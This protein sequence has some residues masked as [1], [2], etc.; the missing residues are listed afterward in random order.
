M[1]DEALHCLQL[2][3]VKT[4]TTA[5]PSET[6]YQD[7]IYVLKFWTSYST[8]YIFMSRVVFWRAEQ[9]KYKGRVKIYN[10]TTVHA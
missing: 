4:T 2:I 1:Y 5:K 3:Q 6:E 7:Q 9:T 8:Q 10:S